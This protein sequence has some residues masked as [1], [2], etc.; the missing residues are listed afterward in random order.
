VIEEVKSATS[1]KEKELLFQKDDL[2][3]VV[4]GLRHVL[5]VGEVMLRKGSEGDIVVGKV[6]IAQRMK[7]LLGI[8]L[9]SEPVCDE[10]IALEVERERDL[11]VKSIREIGSVSKSRSVRTGKAEEPKSVY[12]RDYAKVA[13]KPVLKFGKKGTEDGEF[14]TPYFI[15]SNSRGGD[16]CRGQTQSSCSSV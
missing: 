9:A 8:P 2:E 10:T 16:H 5:E 7:T 11:V 3:F 15:A 13:K 12:H 6:Q 4:V 1:Q 14:Q